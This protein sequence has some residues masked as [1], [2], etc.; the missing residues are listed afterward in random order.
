MVLFRHSWPGN[1]RELENAI[2][3][4]CM[5]ASGDSVDVQDLPEYLRISAQAPPAALPVR[6]DGPSSASFEDHE[7]RLVVQAL[8]RAHGNR[9][10]AAKSL[11]I[12]R[13]AIRYKMKKH[14]LDGVPI[15]KAG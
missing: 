6:I 15:G 12:G 4:G 9:S 10:M 5:M 7:K 13:D 14:G 2:G 3:H 1:V 8:M 11:R